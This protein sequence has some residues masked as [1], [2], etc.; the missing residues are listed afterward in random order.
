M[1]TLKDKVLVSLWLPLIW[2][3]FLTVD[4]VLFVNGRPERFFPRLF[5]DL[6][7]V[8]SFFFFRPGTNIRGNPRGLIFPFFIQ[9]FFW[10]LL[11]FAIVSILS[12]RRQKIPPQ[13]KGRV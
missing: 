11:S 7:F 12:K 10:W 1:K 13:N 9:F 6:V 4:V 8:M 2:V 3:S 5:E